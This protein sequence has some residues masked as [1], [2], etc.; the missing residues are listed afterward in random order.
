MFGFK[1]KKQRCEGCKY[2]RVTDGDGWD[3]YGCYHEPYKGK[4]VAEIK[5]CPK[6]AKEKETGVV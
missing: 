4:W 3:F 5:L 6:K 1:S 2:C